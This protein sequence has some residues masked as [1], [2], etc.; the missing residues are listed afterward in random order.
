MKHVNIVLEFLLIKC[1]NPLHCI[2]FF[3]QKIT[4]FDNAVG[5]Y[6]TS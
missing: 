6:L 5:F 3:Q 4:V 2:T 1:E